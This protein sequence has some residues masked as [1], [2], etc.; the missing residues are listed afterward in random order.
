LKVS[1]FLLLL[2]SYFHIAT[3]H[4]NLLLYSFFSP[5]FSNMQMIPN[6]PFSL[7]TSLGVFSTQEQNTNPNPKPNT[8]VPKKKRN[9]PGTPGIHSFFFLNCKSIINNNRSLH[10]MNRGREKL[11]YIIHCSLQLFILSI[12]SLEP[13]HYACL[14]QR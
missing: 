8:P 6:D 11:N 4:H 13:L 5:F 10:E 14:N 9:L 2:I 1:G 3:F 7:S 12:F